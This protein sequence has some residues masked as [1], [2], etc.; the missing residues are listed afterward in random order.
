MRSPLLRSKKTAVKAFTLLELLV[1]CG[2]LLVL[3]GLLF[4]AIR[5]VKAQGNSTKC[6]A[7]LKQI[8]VLL[9][10]E[11]AD[12]N[13]V[14]KFQ[15]YTTP[16]TTKRWNNYLI[17][18]GYLEASSKIP[19]CPSVAVSNGV[20]ASGMGGYVY[21]GVIFAEATDPY[22]TFVDGISTSRAVRLSSIDRPSQYW[23]LTDS[24]SLQL[25][26]QTYYIDRSSGSSSRMQL[27]HQGRANTLFADGH[28][29][30]MD[31]NETKNYS[32]YPLVNAFDEKGR[33]VTK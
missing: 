25:N 30:G 22:S 6:M 16:G 12:N 19:F 15:S 3:M 32:I 33:G 29:R 1:V 7:N 27:R 11:S 2:V 17:E 28:V 20:M 24:W 26:H 13:G 14:V 23:L 8:G 21:G 5:A 31:L 4:P 10:A 9:H 18:G